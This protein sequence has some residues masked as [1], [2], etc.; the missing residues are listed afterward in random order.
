MWSI[1]ASVHPETPTILFYTVSPYTINDTVK[2]VPRKD[3]LSRDCSAHSKASS[4][5][6]LKLQSRGARQLGLWGC[7]NRG[8]GQ[9]KRGSIALGGR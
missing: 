7:S 4:T 8:C 6:L 3:L 9:C 1:G 5:Y 2:R